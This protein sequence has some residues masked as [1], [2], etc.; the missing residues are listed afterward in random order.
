MPSIQGEAMELFTR[1]PPLPINSSRG[2]GSR[3]SPGGSHAGPAATV[4]F[5]TRSSCRRPST[6]GSDRGIS[7][8]LKISQSGGGVAGPHPDITN[9]N[10]NVVERP[11][12]VRPG[13]RGEDGDDR[14][15]GGAQEQGCASAVSF[16]RCLA[17]SRCVMTSSITCK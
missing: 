1:I 7:G 10:A 8:G 2:E 5:S 12:R 3:G 14:R 11:R 9:A 6:S 13:S 17:V 4:A 16:V 15:N